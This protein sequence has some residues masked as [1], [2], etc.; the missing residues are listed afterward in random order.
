M[1]LRSVENAFKHGVENLREHAFVHINIIAKA[2]KINF[3]IANN[4]DPTEQ[5]AEE[6]IG[7][8]NLKRRLAL[9]YPD[10]HLLAFSKQD[11]VYSAQLNITKL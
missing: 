1:P 5:V 3:S 11:N 4:F 8:K 9:A 2:D 7:L 10:Q 6:G